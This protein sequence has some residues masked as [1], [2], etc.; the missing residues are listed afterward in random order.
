[1]P[2]AKK[3]RSAAFVG[4]GRQLGQLRERLDWVRDG[5]RDQAGK[6]L[7]LRGRRR[8]GKSRLVEVFADAEG[9]PF[10]FFTAAKGAAPA[11][12]VAE[13]LRQAVEESTLSGRQQLEGVSAVDWAT[14]LRLLAQAIPDDEPTIVVIDEV[15]WLAEDD[16]AFEGALQVV[17]D[18]HLSRKPVMLVLIGSDLAMME[19]L[20]S[21]GRPFY[22]RGDEM[23]LDPL[24]LAE[25][26]DMCGLADD[27][28]F[29]AFLI[30]GGLPLVCQD[31]PSG[32]S[33][34]DFLMQAYAKPTSPL[35]VSGE[36][37]LAAE[38]PGAL[39][40]REV[41]EAIGDGERTFTNIAD[42]AGVSHATL[43]NAL[44]GL[45]TK[46]LVDVEEPLSAKSGRKNR[47]FHVADPYLRFWLAFIP[48]AL[49]SVERGRPDLA[50]RHWDQTWIGWRGRAIEPLIRA[51][52]A[53]LLPD[54]RFPAALELGGWWPRNN[55][56]ELD[57]VAADRRPAREIAL[58]GSIKWRD[59]APFDS[60]DF[61]HLATDAVEVPGADASTPLVA[62]S[63]NG[64]QGVDGLAARW[65]PAELVDAWRY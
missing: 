33:P 65:G 50:M 45:L 24:N 1:M 10:L 62:V 15:P 21:Y 56:P 13:L 63:R 31:W 19:A 28:A 22:Q 47:R 32:A 5:G 55:T 41:L 23:I 35:I 59:R 12:S 51:S 18:Q 26:A 20:S 16:P 7:L 57:L 4:R 14:V 60:S 38:L 30:T 49:P 64:F 53:R 39:K 11:A 52:L 17:W 44:E 3:K 29:D 9:V 48:R 34:G 58:V 36:R 42:T 37:I 2:R 8:V 61:G 43:N 25:V 6:A 54:D 40:P 27:V 46:R